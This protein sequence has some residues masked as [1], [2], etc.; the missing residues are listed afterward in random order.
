M[1]RIFY[2]IEVFCTDAVLDA[3]ARR[4]EIE[5]VKWNLS[6]LDG[7]SFWRNC[8]IRWWDKIHCQTNRVCAKR[9]HLNHSREPWTYEMMMIFLCYRVLPQTCA[10]YEFCSSMQ[11][12]WIF[13]R[14]PPPSNLP[15]WTFPSKNRS[16]HLT[17]TP[18]WTSHSGHRNPMTLNTLQPMRFWQP[19]LHLIYSSFQ[20]WQHC[21]FLIDIEWSR[22][23]I[24]GTV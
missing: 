3:E 22:R 20:I 4:F 24:R 11:S 8:W 12:Q 18:T 2:I 21:W 15:Q 19:M 14:H 13:Q 1:W 23:E 17:T 7:T 16:K 6:E 9:L 5:K 10:Y